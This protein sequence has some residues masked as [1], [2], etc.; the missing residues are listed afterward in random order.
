VIRAPELADN[1]F[2]WVGLATNF[3]V[4]AEGLRTSLYQ[5]GADATSLQRVSEDLKEAQV[6]GIEFERPSFDVL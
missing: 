5:F 3:L 6:G 1:L 2:P 4:N